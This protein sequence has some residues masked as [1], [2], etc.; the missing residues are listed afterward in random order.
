MDMQEQYQEY[1]FLEETSE[2]SVGEAEAEAN[3]KMVA[4]IWKTNFSF[5][6][7]IMNRSYENRKWYLVVFKPFNHSYKMHYEWY[8]HKGLDACRKYFKDVDFLLLTKE[9]EAAKTHV[10]ALVCTKTP[11]VDGR[12]TRKYKLCVKPVPGLGDRL[13]VLNYICKE[14]LIRTFELYRDYMYIDKAVACP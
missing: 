4:D 7:T 13:Y 6:K 5:F 9:E 2:A 12:S 1:A 8:Q 14:S 3:L 11:P 10:N